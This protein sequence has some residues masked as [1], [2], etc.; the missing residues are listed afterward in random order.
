MRGVMGGAM[1]WRWR[2]WG[3]C[4]LISLRRGGRGGRGVGGEGSRLRRGGSGRLLLLSP[5][6]FFF[7]SLHW[8]CGSLGK[9]RIIAKSG[10]IP[11]LF[12]AYCSFLLPRRWIREGR[13]RGKRLPSKG[14]AKWK[15][16]FFVFVASDGLH[17]ERIQDWKYR[18][19]WFCFGFMRMAFL[20]LD[21]YFLLSAACV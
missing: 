12:P 6:S 8:R 9:W 7:L 19:R 3:I 16:A 21:F 1:G 14:K 20:L 15:R 4:M 2:S 18:A 17:C 11:F 10:S 5:S 13:E